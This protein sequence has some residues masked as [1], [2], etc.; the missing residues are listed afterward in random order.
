MKPI[1]LTSLSAG[2]SCAALLAAACGAAD[3]PSP[4]PVGQRINAIC[5]DESQESDAG[6]EPDDGWECD[7]KLVVECGSGETHDAGADGAGGAAGA[8]AGA[9]GAAGADSGAGGADSGAAGADSGAGGSDADDD[10]MVKS[11]R[12]PFTLRVPTE[13]I[14]QPCDDVKL[15]VPTRIITTAVG[16]S[17]VVVEAKPISG[18][19]AKEICDAEVEVVDTTPPKATSRNV[20]L[21]PPNHRMQRIAPE[22]C[23]TIEDACDEDVDVWFTAMSS[24]EPANAKGDGNHEPDLMLADGCRAVDVRAERSGKGNGRVY[25]LRWHAVDD[26]GNAAEGVC[27]VTVPHDQSGS[28]AVDDGPAYTM[29]LTC[30]D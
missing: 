18:G 21:W 19:N 13:L 1:R 30:E 29:D 20:V 6:T 12:A 8:D 27:Q 26:A 7:E 4:E 23:V 28:A 14:E 11:E 2:I 15:H 10:E 17:D 22:D 3:D 5:V 24:D 16:T 9:G 25:S